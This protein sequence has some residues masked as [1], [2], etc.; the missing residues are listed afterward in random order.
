[1]VESA[2]IRRWKQELRTRAQAARREQP[3]KEALSARIWQRVFERAEYEQAATVMTYVG[4][5]EEVETRP[6]LPRIRADHKRIVV[7]Y[8][9]SGVLELFPLNDLDELAP[10]TFGLLEPKRELRGL[11][12]RQ[13]SVEEL[14]F[15][16]TPGVAFD[17]QGG[18]L[19]HGKGYYDKL[20]RRL[21][22]DAVVLGIA[23]ECQVLAEVPMLP[24]DVPMD[25]VATEAAV[26]Q[27]RG[28][29]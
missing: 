16:I 20:L 6:F 25:H 26:Y 27:G 10:S 8:C 23:F 24:H 12:D 9:R 3:D 1:V 18:R 29:Q 21:R 4:V 17:R 11:P 2:D 14:D 19:G 28:R 7:P 22:A 13:V 15:V 5:G